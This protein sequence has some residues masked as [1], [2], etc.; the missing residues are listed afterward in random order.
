MACQCLI[1]EDLTLGNSI[2]DPRIS[3]MEFIWNEAALNLIVDVRV[4]FTRILSSR[5]DDFT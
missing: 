4:G 1:L 5:M 3:L 2:R